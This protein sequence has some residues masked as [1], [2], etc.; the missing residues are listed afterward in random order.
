MGLLSICN[1]CGSDWCVGDCEDYKHI[2]AKNLRR[3]AGRISYRPIAD[4]LER[5][6]IYF[7]RAPRV[8]AD[9][10]DDMKEGSE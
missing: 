5:I 2:T 7:E 6:A 1:K 4:D 8:L 3:L 9:A 10:L